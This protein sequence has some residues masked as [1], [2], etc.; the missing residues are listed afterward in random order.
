MASDWQQRADFGGVGRHR[1]TAI[2]I[3]NKGYMGLGHY[4]GTGINIVKK[5]W[6]EFD[7][8]SNAWTQKSNYPNNGDYAVVTFT[9]NNVCYVGTGQVSSAFH[10]YDPATNT[11]TLLNSTPVSFNNTTAMMVED[12]AFCFVP[13]TNQMYEYIPTSDTWVLKNVVPFSV[14]VWNS[15]F[16]IAEKGYVKTGNQLW[17]YKPYT[18][19]W[20]QRSSCPGIATS[21]SV[22]FSQYNKGYI[23]CGFGGSLSNVTSEVWEYDPII[24][25]WNALEEFP[26]AS[27]RFS[28]GF[29]IG[30][31]CFFGIGTNGTNFNDFWEFDA[32]ASSESLTKFVPFNCYPNPADESIHFESKEISIYQL[33][34][35]D[36]TG[37]LIQSVNTT[38]GKI[39]LLRNE[40]TS[41][42]YFG[43]IEVD[44]KKIE[45]K[46]FIFK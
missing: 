12:R 27:R 10:K 6:W 22:G 19:Q 16:S 31:K 42:F 34:I 17:E 4:N 11:W 13:Y 45:N 20:I 23:V 40:Y 29:S 38:N 30:N 18:D 33:H 41:G 39:E 25:Q 28:A 7:P 26:G 2:S 36:A 35:F 44:G 9:I 46:S 5:D 3:G 37:N 21:A 24:N 15:T 32:L 8:A 43:T 1:G 14:N